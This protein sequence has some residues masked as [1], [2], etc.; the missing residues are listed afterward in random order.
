MPSSVPLALSPLPSTTPSS[1]P[2]PPKLLS[3]PTISLS[4]PAPKLKTPI[5][6][7]RLSKVCQQ[8][9]P[10]LARNCSTLLPALLLLSGTQSSLASFA[11]TC[12]MKPFCSMPA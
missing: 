4:P 12:L 2:Q 10:H 3:S 9:Q 7:S 1:P 8:G 6:R 5:I 11:T